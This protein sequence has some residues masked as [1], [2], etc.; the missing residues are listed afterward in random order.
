MPKSA[1]TVTIDRED[2]ERIDAWVSQG[3]FPNR[4]QAIG[5]ALDL[6][7]A[8]QR[9]PTLEEALREPRFPEGSSEALAAA[10]ESDAIDRWA[11]AAEADRL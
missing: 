2:L 11:E 4:S 8:Q 9:R 6:L 5:A 1:V 10:S 3:R 7:E